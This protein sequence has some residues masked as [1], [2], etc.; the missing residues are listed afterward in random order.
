[1]TEDNSQPGD[2][3][4]CERKCTCTCICNCQKGE[5]PQDDSKETS[6]PGDS[7]QCKC[8]CKCTCN[9]QKGKSPQD[10][11]KKTSIELAK[12]IGVLSAGMIAVFYNIAKH[13]GVGHKLIDFS[14]YVGLV[15][16][17]ASFLCSVMVIFQH[18]RRDL[19]L[20]PNMKDSKQEV[21]IMVLSFMYGMIICLISLVAVLWLDAWCWIST[22][23][24]SFISHLSLHFG[25]FVGC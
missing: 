23:L 18:L 17:L 22:S 2:S 24:M 20:N 19:N 9:C 10:D 11:Y 4:Q 3:G 1:M 6:Q 14:I 8:N 15:L 12:H 13:P 16:I 7:G 25:E 21:K 5:C